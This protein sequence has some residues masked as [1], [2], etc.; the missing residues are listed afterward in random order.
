MECLKLLGGDFTE[1]IRGVMQYKAQRVLLAFLILTN[2]TK[3]DKIMLDDNDDDDH[4]VYLQP[5]LLTETQSGLQIKICDRSCSGSVEIMKV[6]AAFLFT[7]L[8]VH[9]RLSR[10]SRSVWLNFRHFF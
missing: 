6:S 9:Y 3:S 5:T 2:G 10:H 7:P 8:L 4:Q 1:I